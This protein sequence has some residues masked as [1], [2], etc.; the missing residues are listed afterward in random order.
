MSDPAYSIETIGKRDTTVA[1]EQARPWW[2]QRWMMLLAG[3][4]LSFLTGMAFAAWVIRTGDWHGGMLWER[5]LMYAMHIPLPTWL[6]R[7]MLLFP[8]L[9]TNIT[10]IPGVL[11]VV[12][13]LWWKKHRP[14][15]AMRLLIIQ[16]GSYSLNPA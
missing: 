6:D 15:L 1:R 11:A 9:G 13:W 7:L 10:L 3:Y 4:C 14:H 2:R 8:W 16:L 12:V 5:K